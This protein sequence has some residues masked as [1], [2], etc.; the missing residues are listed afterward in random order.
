[1][2]IYDLFLVL[3]GMT[4]GVIAAEP[5]KKIFTGKYTQDKMQQKRVKLLTHLRK[6]PGRKKSTEA[7]NTE[8]FNGKEKDDRIY[9]LLKDIEETKLIRSTEKQNTMYWQFDQ[10][11]YEKNKHKFR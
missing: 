1:M 5:L 4:I 6:N 10:K 11:E 9:Q 3:F 7:L 8:I 2:W